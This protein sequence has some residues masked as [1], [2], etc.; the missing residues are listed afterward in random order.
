MQ[1]YLDHVTTTKLMMILHG[2]IFKAFM[3]FDMF[4]M[5]K[6]IFYRKHIVMSFIRMSAWEKSIFIQ[7]MAWY[8]Q[9]TSHYLIH[10][11]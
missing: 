11:A 3:N 2:N 7:L 8:Q 6:W 9:A 10:D 5:T 1:L 4:V